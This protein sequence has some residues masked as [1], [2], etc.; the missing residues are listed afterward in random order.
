[1]RFR[2][3]LSAVQRLRTS[4]VQATLP[5]SAYRD[6]RTLQ[7]AEVSWVQRFAALPRPERYARVAAFLIAA[8]IL[9]ILAC[10]AVYI[11]FFHRHPMGETEDWGAFGAFISGAAGTA[12]SAFTLAALAFTL[13]LQ[14]DEL[15]E[16]RK[17]ANEQFKVLERQSATM[18]QQAFDSAFFNL[19]ERFNRVRENVT[20]EYREMQR[21]INGEPQLVY[22]KASGRK[23][24][25]K[26][27]EA[28]QTS[29]GPESNQPNRRAA[30][31]GIFK[32]F[33]ELSES[34]LGPYFRTLYHIFKYV[35]NEPQLTQQQKINYANIARA[36]LSD[37]EL[38][39]LFYDGLTNLAPKF[40]PLIECYGVLKHVN[41]KHLLNTADKTDESM[42]QRSAF[43][44]QEERE[45]T[46]AP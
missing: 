37:V 40:K 12:L 46:A 18:A 28:L 25:E 10:I 2:Q 3:G 5:R 45:A 27:Y 20:V 17:L 41:A 23:A 16:S 36:Q 6:T 30:L 9:S 19:L 31:E 11:F 22:L 15:A 29:I 44:S 26:F 39:V 43:Q 13:A 33:Y 7:D 24:F 1:M 32:P 21:D 38:C 34:D 4:T 35:D 8:G 14:A 42:Y